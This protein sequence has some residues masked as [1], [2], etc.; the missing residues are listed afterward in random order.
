[1]LKEKDVAGDSFSDYF[2]IQDE[3]NTKCSWCKKVIYFGSAGKV[4]LSQHAKS[5]GHRQV[6][7]SRNQR[8][9]GQ[10]L[11]FQLWGN[12]IKMKIA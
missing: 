12:L 11:F 5:K 7:D 9:S 1:M 3:Y 6:A 4:A 8:N 10:F 2:V